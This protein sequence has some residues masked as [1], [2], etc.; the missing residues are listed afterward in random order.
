MISSGWFWAEVAL[1]ISGGLIVWYGLRIEKRA[2]RKLSPADLS[3][4]VFQDGILTLKRELERGWR[5][6]MTGIVV[7][8][9]AAFGITVLSG[10]EVAALNDEAAKARLRVAELETKLRHRQIR[11]EDR[12]KFVALLA[13]A[14]KGK[15]EV[16]FSM[17]A[18]DEIA[19][20]AEQIRRM[21]GAAGYDVG[22]A[23]GFVQAPIP[24]VMGIGVWNATNQPPFAGQMQ[25][26]LKAIGIDTIGYVNSRLRTN[27]VQVFVGGKADGGP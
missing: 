2:E 22:R 8:V 13:N 15:V 27:Q 26:A 25:A 3:P 5:I 9:V 19:D 18:G 21:I 10:L 20:Y 6:L 23:C 16:T 12:Q 7:E 1:S 11:S 24:K 4:E 14:P 17:G